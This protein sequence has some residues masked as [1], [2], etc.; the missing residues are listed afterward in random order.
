MSV[1]EKS[2]WYCAGKKEMSKTQEKLA[3]EW[4]QFYMGLSSD[5]SGVGCFKQ[6]TQQGAFIFFQEEESLLIR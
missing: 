1:L 2:N 6:K 3:S 4:K 5:G